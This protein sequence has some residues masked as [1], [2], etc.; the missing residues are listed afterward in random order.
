[1][2]IRDGR[3]LLRRLLAYE[4]F[5]RRLAHNEESTLSVS[6]LLKPHCF[7]SGSVGSVYFWASCFGILIRNLFVRIRTLPSINKKIKNNLV[8]YDFLPLKNHV[9]VPSKRNEHK[10]LREKKVFFVGFLKITDENSRVRSRILIQI[11]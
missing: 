2:N 3:E 7:G 11:R 1:M 5:P 9:N 4:R 6:V 8:L 10:I